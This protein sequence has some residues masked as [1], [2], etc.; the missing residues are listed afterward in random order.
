MIAGN[1]YLLV[2]SSDTELLGKSEE[3]DTE[4]GSFHISPHC[5]TS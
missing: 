1:I 4:R 3:G 2:S 5:D